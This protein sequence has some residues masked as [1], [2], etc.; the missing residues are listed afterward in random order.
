MLLRHRLGRDAVPVFGY[1]LIP[2]V[3]IVVT[4]G[5]ASFLAISKEDGALWGAVTVLAGL[6]LY[7]LC[8]RK[9]R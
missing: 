2:L 9:E 3:Y 4:L 8:R 5:A 6:P 7:F 1:P